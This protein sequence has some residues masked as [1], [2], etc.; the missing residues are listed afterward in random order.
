MQ[1]FGDGTMKHALLA[2]V[3]TVASAAFALDGQFGIHDPSTVVLCDGKYYTWGTGGSPL[4]SDDGWTWRAGV[5]PARGGMAPDVIHLGD[6]YYMYVGSN[7]GGQPHGAINM[8]WSKTL[9]PNSPD[10]KWEDGGL[11]ASSDGIDDCKAIE[12][13]AFV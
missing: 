8:I 3:L 6:R 5:R 2:I 9:D 11:V 7:P 12:P 1:P 4:V 10:Y 13:G